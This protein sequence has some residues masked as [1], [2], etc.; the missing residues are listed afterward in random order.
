M[1]L[2]KVFKLSTV[3]FIQTIGHVQILTPEQTMVEMSGT[4][5]TTP[6]EDFKPYF[7]ADEDDFSYDD[8]DDAYTTN[9]LDFKP[10]LGRKS[11]GR[12]RK[13]PEKLGPKRP[14]GRPRK[15]PMTGNLSLTNFR[16]IFL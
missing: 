14:R 3:F 4:V 16:L 12:P 9:S 15:F 1:K 6:N 2:F 11:R 8:D 7:S 5:D 13:H 10:P